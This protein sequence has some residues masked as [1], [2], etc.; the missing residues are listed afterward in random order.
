MEVLPIQI[1][2]MILDMVKEVENLELSSFALSCKSH[3]QIYLAYK[4]TTLLTPHQKTHVDEIYNF[5]RKS[6]IAVDISVM[7]SGKTYAACGLAKKLGLELTVVCP[8]SIVNTWIDVCKVFKIR[9]ILITTYGKIKPKNG[10]LYLTSDLKA[11]PE[12]KKRVEEGTLLIYDE[13][14]ALKNKTKQTLGALGLNDPINFGNNKSKILFI[15]S[16]P[17]DKK[18]QIPN[19]C[20][21][22]GFTDKESMGEYDH[23]TFTYTLT[24][25]ADMIDYC[26]KHFKINPR[27]YYKT[28]SKPKDTCVRLFRNCV[29]QNITFAM[30]PPIIRSEFDL[31]N[32]YY[33]MAEDKKNKLTGAIRAIAVMGEPGGIINWGL[34]SINMRIAEMSKIDLIIRLVKDVLIASPKNKVIVMAFY[35]DTITQITDAFKNYGSYSL[36]GD[37]D[38]DT[39]KIKVDSFNKNIKNKVLVCNLRVGAFG[40]SLHDTKG[41]S[42][43]YLFVLPNYYITLMH[44]ATR[45]IYRV[46][47]K[48]KATARFVYCN[49]VKTEERIWRSLS[50]KSEIL[51]SIGQKVKGVTY[52]TDLPS[53][54]EPRPH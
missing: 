4:E 21:L 44:Q 5:Y 8:K 43:R 22:F 16:T 36:T 20:R 54:I 1:N 32:G 6:K 53:Y 46:G 49:D 15:S 3:Y 12:W 37:D 47:T 23:S 29:P 27:L 24:G 17:I 42:P 41:D 28:T 25:L 30:P 13:C 33:H 52:P 45:R 40:I 10:N 11:T 48:S 18:E 26:S 35:I 14:D 39:R 38:I 51:S 50:K 9:E 34:L 2:F 7:G 19:F 31:K